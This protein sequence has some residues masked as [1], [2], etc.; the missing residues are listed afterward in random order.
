MKRKMRD[1]LKLKAQH[2]SHSDYQLTEWHSTWP[3]LKL[4]TSSASQQETKGLLGVVLN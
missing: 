4:I 1:F 2:C 3:S